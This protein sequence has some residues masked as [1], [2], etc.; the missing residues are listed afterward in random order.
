MF[1]DKYNILIGRNIFKNK[2]KEIFNTN[3]V[4]FIDDISK[5]ILKNKSKFIY[6]EIVS[7]GFWCRKKNILNLKKAFGEDHLRIGKGKIFHITP[8]NVPINFAYSLV[9]GLLAGNYNIVRVHSKNCEI[10][11]TICGII[12]RN[13]KKRKFSNLKEYIFVINYDSSSKITDEIS[14]ISDARI[15]W[16]GDNTVKKIKSIRSKIDSID[17]SF[18]DRYSMSIINLD[19]INLRNLD[20]IVTKFYNDTYVMDQA[21]C[22]SPHLIIWLNNKKNK[23]IYNKFWNE[24]FN[25]AKKK[26]N[27]TDY[28]GFNKF[29]K[30]NE[31]LIY[32]NKNVI[33][34]QNYSNFVHITNIKSLN[35]DLDKIRGL[36]GSFY[37]INISNFE[38]LKKIKSEKLQTLTYFGLEKNFLTNLL[39]KNYL[40]GISR[41]CPIGRALNFGLVWDGKDLI[42]SL[43]KIIS[44]E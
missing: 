18:P 36:G 2:P 35:Y 32:L 15:I 6:P 33:S 12:K 10:T 7:F 11:N 24:L 9:V 4:D 25:L 44:V 22:S 23:T 40:L 27:L 28:I 39:K 19:K 5:S 38:L 21:A 17:V 31:N 29:Q 37:N 1:K 43:S 14:Q 30:S 16:G 20:D 8:K 13:L 3:I 34:F 42:R 41:V 26:Y